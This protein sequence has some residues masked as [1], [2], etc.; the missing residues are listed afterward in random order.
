MFD[1][2]DEILHIEQDKTVKDKLVLWAGLFSIGV[3]KVE[4]SKLL[5]DIT[6]KVFGEENGVG[7]GYVLPF[8]IG[9]KMY[10]SPKEP[11]RCLGHAQLVTIDSSFRYGRCAYS[12]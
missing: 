2:P 8:S 11:L 3:A 12:W 7:E 1:F 6:Y 10:Y 4:C 9:D 5:K